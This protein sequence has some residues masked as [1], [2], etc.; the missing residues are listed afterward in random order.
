MNDI[1]LHRS[2]GT[3]VIIPAKYSSLSVPK[4]DV[5]A[6]SSHRKFDYE[7]KDKI[8]QFTTLTQKE[9]QKM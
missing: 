7:L 8:S 9:I 1:G 6:T 5:A 2:D 3:V 4:V